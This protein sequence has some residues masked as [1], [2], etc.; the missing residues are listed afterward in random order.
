MVE[1]CCAHQRSATVDRVG[2]VDVDAV[3]KRLSNRI[4]VTSTRRSEKVLYSRCGSGGLVAER[5]GE[6]SPGTTAHGHDCQHED[7]GDDNVPD[8]GGHRLCLTRHHFTRV[9]IYRE[10]PVNGLPGSPVGAGSRTSTLSDVSL[11]KIP[12]AQH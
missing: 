11:L 12:L 1:R 9:S 8:E 3:R 10:L 4:H 6:I 5:R 2:R 7:Q